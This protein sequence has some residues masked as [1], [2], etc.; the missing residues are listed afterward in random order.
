MSEFVEVAHI[1]EF[2]D[3]TMKKVTAGDIQI[4][5]ARANGKFYASQHLCPHLGADLSE[6]TLRG[7][8]L[9]CPM[10]NSQFDIRDGHVVR[11]T[12]L[13]GI[14]LSYASKTHPPRSLRCF[15]VRVEGEMVLVSAW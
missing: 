13:T 12:N 9:T 1:S 10:H 7:T 5:L 11:W 15:P 14:K 3:G 8:V 4:L 6:G 2:M